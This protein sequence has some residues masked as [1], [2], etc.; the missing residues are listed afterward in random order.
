MSKLVQ[1]RKKQLYKFKSSD[2][3]DRMYV[4]D[5]GSEH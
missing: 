2:T 1:R 5:T 4:M 3:A